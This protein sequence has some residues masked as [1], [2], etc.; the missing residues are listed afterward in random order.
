MH[1]GRG[2]EERK[3]RGEKEEEGKEKK[4]EGER[5]GGGVEILVCNCKLHKV[6]TLNGAD[7]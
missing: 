6:G 2:G 1:Q 7:D 4:K 5:G 3:E